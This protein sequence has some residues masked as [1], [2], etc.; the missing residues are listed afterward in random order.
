M[1]NDGYNKVFKISRIA[2]GINYGGILMI[3]AYLAGLP[4]LYEGEDIEVRYC[5]YEDQ[6]LVTKKSVLLE[7]RKPA[8]VGQVALIT[9]LKGLKNYAEK[10]IVII[11][12]DAALYEFIKGSST[13]KNKDVLEI[14]NETRKVLSK[15]NHYTLQD[16]SRDKVERMNWSEILQP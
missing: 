12:N 4:S 14:E 3:K 11:I 9:L 6:K 8:I 13:T 15:F 10:E 16:V 7:Y 5:I 2:L 1:K